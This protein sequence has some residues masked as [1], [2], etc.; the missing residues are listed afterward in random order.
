VRAAL[1]RLCAALGI[2]FSDRMLNWAAGPKH[3]DGVWAPHWYN[4]VHAS[5]G[6]GTAEAPLPALTGAFARL[7]D[8]AMPFYERLKAL[9]L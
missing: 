5:T 6:F 7:S 3:Y 2:G 1:A 9:A 4:A 8:R